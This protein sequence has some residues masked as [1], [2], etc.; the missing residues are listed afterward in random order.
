MP[1]R[2]RNSPRDG[3]KQRDGKTVR[4][5]QHG[6][7]GRP[8]NICARESKKDVAHVHDAG[9]TEHPIEALLRNRD[10]TDINDVA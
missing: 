2:F 8:E 1:V 5:H 9:I 4:E 6:S 10:K 3:K 7:P